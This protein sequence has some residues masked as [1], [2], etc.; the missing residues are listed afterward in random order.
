MRVTVQFNALLSERVLI[1][2]EKPMRYT[3]VSTRIGLLQIRIAAHAC[4]QKS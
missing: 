4:I 1:R 2:V 3:C